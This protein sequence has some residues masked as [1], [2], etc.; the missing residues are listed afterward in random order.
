MVSGDWGYQMPAAQKPYGLLCVITK[1]L[2]SRVVGVS[3]AY[4]SYCKEPGGLGVTPTN[5]H[6]SYATTHL[7]PHLSSTHGVRD[8]DTRF[9]TAGY[10]DLPNPSLN[11]VRGAA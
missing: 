11:S 1:F 7:R 8:N 5:F 2:T 4:C 9:E 3:S 10:W 6:L